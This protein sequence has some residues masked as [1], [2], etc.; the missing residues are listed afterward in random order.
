[1]RIIAL[2]ELQPVPLLA[3]I[4]FSQTGEESGIKIDFQQVLEILSVST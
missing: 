4:L 2:G 3:K 1:M